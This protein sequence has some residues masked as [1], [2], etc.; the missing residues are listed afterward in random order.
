M[1]FRHLTSLAL[2]GVPLF[3]L[4]P[5]PP[6][7]SIVS[8]EIVQAEISTLPRGNSI[9]FPELEYLKLDGNNLVLEIP[10]SWFEGMSV[11]IEVIHLRNNG[12]FKLPEVLPVKSRFRFLSLV[13]NNL[14]TIPD[15]LACQSLTRILIRFNPVTWDEKLCWRRL[16]DRV[17]APLVGKDDVEC[18]GPLPLRATMLSNVNPKAMGCYNGKLPSYDTMVCGGGGGGGGNG[19][20]CIYVLQMWMHSNFDWYNMIN[21]TVVFQDCLTASSVY[22]DL[23]E[24]VTKDNQIPLHPLHERMKAAGW[25][26]L[27]HL[28]H[29][30]DESYR[31]IEWRLY[32][33]E[34]FQ[35]KSQVN[36]VF[37]HTRR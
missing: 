3:D 5:P 1:K 13:S 36:W 12:I 29:G 30:T 25:E 37:F 7:P 6:P 4:C 8:L 23:N 28:C 26:A 21:S 20:F 14:L 33:W 34:V 32:Q 17:R 35:F 11:N 31:Y 22:R 9:R 19:V 2:A 24:A 16:W 27:W 15:M 18:Q 10:N